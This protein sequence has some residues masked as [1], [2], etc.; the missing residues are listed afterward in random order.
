MVWHGR[1]RSRK[2]RDTHVSDDE[3]LANMGHPDD[4]AIEEGRVVEL[5]GKNGRVRE[6]DLFAALRMTNLEG[7]FFRG[8]F[9]W[10]LCS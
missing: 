8:Y 4:A 10:K 7:I 9:L 3:A 1:E 2:A 5:R 6:A